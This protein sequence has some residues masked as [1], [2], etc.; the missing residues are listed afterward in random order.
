MSS[1]DTTTKAIC[2]RSDTPD[3][4]LQGEITYGPASGADVDLFGHL[5][6]SFDDQKLTE[7]FT[8]HGL[9]FKAKPF[10]LFRCLFSG[11][12]INLPGGQSCKLIS[13]S[14]IIGGHYSS[15][16]EV[17][18]KKVET[19]FLWLREWICRSGIGVKPEESPRG[20]TVTYQVL[21]P[22]AFGR[23]DGLSVRVEFRGHLQPNFH[24]L[25]IDEDCVL[26]IE[27]DSLR[28]YSDF[29][30]YLNA[31]QHFLCLAV[32]RPVYPLRTVGYLDKPREVINGE[33]IFEEFVLVRKLAL[34]RGN[35][36]RLLPQEQLFVMPEIDSSPESLFTQFVER[37]QKL[38]ASMDLYF[39]IMYRDSVTPRV[40]FL[41]L[42]QSLEAY[43]RAT[44]PE[45][46]MDDNDY[47][48]GLR[49]KLWN[50][51]ATSSEIDGSFRASLKTK[52]NYLHE[53]S[54]RKRLRELALRHAPILE[55]LVGDADE[56][57]ATVSELRNR[58]THPD[59]SNPQVE[60]DFTVLLRL[61]EQMALLLEVCF[62]AELGFDTDR[63]KKIIFDRS[64]RAFALH[65]RWI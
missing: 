25:K 56:F 64:R 10:S 59:A 63:I 11:A 5:Y 62:L 49:E 40:E 26:V 19:H 41:T 55:S 18:F 35:R 9:T 20:V 12:E 21:P 3:K 61:S 36:E 22:V 7:R 51:I 24:E 8:L 13:T 44:T 16:E 37:Q 34:P 45:K 27:A 47:N 30:R 32:Q 29:E 53:F 58:F 57:A 50:V 39:S 48:Q 60:T 2:W 6:D 46:Y 43:H 54:L 28:P 31:F 65:R 52:L 1:D 15:L 17:A 42:A 14:G 38:Q 4:R 23:Y 33:P